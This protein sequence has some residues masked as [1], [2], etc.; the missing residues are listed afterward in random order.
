V[1]Q[2]IVITLEVP[3]G[4]KVI[5]VQRAPDVEPDPAWAMEQVTA[6][7]PAA[8]TFTATTPEFAP[9]EAKRPPNC[10]IHHKEMRQ[11]ARGFYCATRLEDGKWCTERG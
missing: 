1:S 7:A 3:D 10:R 4:T 5:E 8:P 6:T 9:F 11:N 2:R